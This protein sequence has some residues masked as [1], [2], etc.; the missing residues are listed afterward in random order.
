MTLA[1]TVAAAAL[2]LAGCSPTGG[3]KT[4]VTDGNSS[5]NLVVQHVNVDGRDVTCVAMLGAKRGGLS[6]DWE[7]AEHRR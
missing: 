3:S 5:A 6:C 7:H 4:G 2:C 1:L